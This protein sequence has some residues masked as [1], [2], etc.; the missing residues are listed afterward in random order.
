MSGSLDAVHQRLRQ[1]VL[2]AVQIDAQLRLDDPWAAAHDLY[3]AGQIRLLRRLDRGAENRVRRVRFQ[4]TGYW[5]S[6]KDAV[7]GPLKA[8]PTLS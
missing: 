2:R 3:H 6:I 7:T 4:R 8:D 1:A 5:I